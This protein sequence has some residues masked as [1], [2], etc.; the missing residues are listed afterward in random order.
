[1]VYNN[2]RS[3][4]KKYSNNNGQSV[5]KERLSTDGPSLKKPNTNFFL[6]H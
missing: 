1:M 6:Q 4:A 3:V 5:V 2:G